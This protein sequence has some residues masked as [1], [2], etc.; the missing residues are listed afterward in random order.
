ME[1]K[2]AKELVKAFDGNAELALFYIAW[3]KNGLNS[4]RAYLELHPN[5]TQ[6][7]AE[8]LGSRVLGKVSKEMI[9]KAYSLDIGKYMLQL[10]EGLEATRPISASILVTKDGKLI[11]AADHGAIE[12]PD[13]M[14]RKFYHDKLGKLLG[15]ET[16]EW[17]DF[18]QQNNFFNLKDEQYRRI[19]EE[20]GFSD[21]SEKELASILV[22]GELAN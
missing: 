8:V 22:E 16:R 19:T 17:N 5:V 3:L 1:N 2:E 18:H 12:V 9:L 6:G 10:K 7:S 11:K 13:H 21:S 4:T 14:T 15:I 20:A